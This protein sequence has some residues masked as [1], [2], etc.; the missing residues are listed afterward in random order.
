M[1]NIPSTIGPLLA[2][3]SLYMSKAAPNNSLVI[4]T[5]SGWHPSMSTFHAKIWPQLLIHTLR[6]KCGQIVDKLHYKSWFLNSSR[7]SSGP[8]LLYNCCFTACSVVVISSV[9]VAIIIIHRVTTKRGA[10]L[11]FILL[12]LLLLLYYYYL[13][14]AR[15]PAG[16]RVFERLQGSERYLVSRKI[17]ERY[18]ELKWKTVHIIMT[19][20][21]QL[22]AFQL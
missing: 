5:S 6:T 4:M 1:S 15:V 2:S 16:S 21:T 8:H 17:T 19:M 18:Q 10:W 20:R 7:E 11:F 3:L 22:T 13:L 9:S 12:L 14:L